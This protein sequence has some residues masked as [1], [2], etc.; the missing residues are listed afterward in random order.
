L[1]L[2]FIVFYILEGCELKR[3]RW[4]VQCL[5]NFY[6]S[7]MPELVVETTY[8]FDENTDL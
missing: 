4:V 1:L 2:P 7:T 6:D 5:I 8:S 3:G